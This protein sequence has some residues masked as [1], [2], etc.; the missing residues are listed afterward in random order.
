MLLKCLVSDGEGLK[1]AESKLV[2][3]VVVPRV[4]KYTW[5]YPRLQYKPSAQIYS[6]DNIGSVYEG[7]SF[8]DSSA[9]GAVTTR[10]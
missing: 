9:I 5:G 1:L 2:H 10:R 7:W 8:W 6:S 4:F 3:Y